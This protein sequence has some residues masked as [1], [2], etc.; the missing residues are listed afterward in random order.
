MSEQA[1]DK[2]TKELAAHKLKAVAGGRFIHLSSQSDKANGLLALKGLYQIKF[3]QHIIQTIAL[4]DSPNDLGMLNAS[5]I[6]IVI[7]NHTILEPSAEKVIFAEDKGPAGW[8]TSI[9]N[10]I[11][12]L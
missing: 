10:I 6:A 1:Y 9:K 3:P 11:N 4:G 8:D 5:D 7:P 12:T 2:F